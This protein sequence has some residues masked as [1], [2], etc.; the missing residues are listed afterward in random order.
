MPIPLV[1]PKL[2]EPPSPERP[3]RRSLFR[4]GL[5]GIGWLAA[6]PIEWAGPGRV[7]RGAVFIADMVR[8][9]RAD[10]CQDR[11]FKTEEDGAFDLRA[12]AFSYGLSAPELARRLAAR[13]R[14]TARLAYATF[15]LACLFLAAWLW[16]ALSAPLTAMRLAT[17]IEF[18]PF[19]ALFFLVAFYNALLNFQ[20]RIGRMATW[21]EYLSTP[22]PFLPR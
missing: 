3:R 8:L 13:R 4:R 12:T 6:G 15:V 21:R 7:R 17:A 11:R 19:C 9:L 16:Q 1:T 22:L 2:S 18:L 20:I 5:R 14:Q 10:P